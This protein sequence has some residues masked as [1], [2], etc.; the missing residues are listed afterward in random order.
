M[1]EEEKQ[2]TDGLSAPV[3]CGSPRASAALRSGDWLRKGGLG[4]PDRSLIWIGARRG[5]ETCREGTRGPTSF[6]STFH[7]HIFNKK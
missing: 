5:T 1:E 6:T 3:R 7:G 2:E 4:P